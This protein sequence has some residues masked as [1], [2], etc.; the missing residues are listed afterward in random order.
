MNS[1]GAGTVVALRAKVN[2]LGQVLSQGLKRTADELLQE[3]MFLEATEQFLREFHRLQVGLGMKLSNKLLEG[4]AEELPEKKDEQDCPFYGDKLQGN[5]LIIS[6]SIKDY[7]QENRQGTT[8]FYQTIESRSP[9]QQAEKNMPGHLQSNTQAKPQDSPS[10]VGIKKENWFTNSE[11]LM[12][13]KLNFASRLGLQAKAASPAKITKPCRLCSP[14]QIGLP[15]N[16]Q[17]KGNNITINQGMTK[18]NIKFN[19]KNIFESSRGSPAHNSLLDTPL[20]SSLNFTPSKHFSRGEF[21]LE[22]QKASD[23]NM[24]SPPNEHSASCRSDLCSLLSPSDP[25][26]S[27]SYSLTQRLRLP[28]PRTVQTIQPDSSERDDHRTSN[29]HSVMQNSTERD[30]V[31]ASPKLQFA[32]TRSIPEEVEFRGMRFMSQSPRASHPAQR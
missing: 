11:K 3:E 4:L 31:K 32:P 6:S 28:Q 17:P 7:Q 13:K 30:R 8:Y 27:S 19:T 9:A 23:P 26:E 22:F 10:F 25:K 12:P 24:A 2:R 29:D 21:G 14:A 5:K 16:L 18:I 15:G 1:S 20:N